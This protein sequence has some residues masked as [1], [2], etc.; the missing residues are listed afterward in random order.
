MIDL[1]SKTIVASIPVGMHPFDVAVDA[2]THTVYVDSFVAPGIAAIDP[3][4][5]VVTPIALPPENINVRGLLVD[6]AARILYAA[7]TQADGGAVLMIDTDSHTVTHTIALGQNSAA[8]DLAVD[9]ITHA[10]YAT[11]FAA[12]AVLV[13]DPDARTVSHLSVNKQT[14]GV[15]VDPTSHAVYVGCPNDNTVIVID[16]RSQVM[17]NIAVGRQP[18][19]MAADAG[20]HTVYVA[21]EVDGT[22]S[23][24]DTRTGRQVTIPVGQNPQRIAAD[25]VT[26]AVVTANTASVSVIERRRP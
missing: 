13:V 8:R 5:R 17:S 15:A 7:V 24:I 26:H 1:P 9:Q 12:N 25:P 16:P 6:T 18:A 10:V 22:A 3:T 20:V 21:N 23:A 2:V 11:D 4:T 14:S 19:G